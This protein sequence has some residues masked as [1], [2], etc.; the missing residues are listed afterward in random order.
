VIP[1]EIYARMRERFADQILEFDESILNPAIKLVPEVVA[2][3]GQYLRDDAEL[4]FNY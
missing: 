3:V 4:Q 2:E 1:T